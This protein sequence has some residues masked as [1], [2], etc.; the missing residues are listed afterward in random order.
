MREGT[1]TRQNPMVNVARRGTGRLRTIPLAVLLL[2]AVSCA[3][4]AGKASQAEPGE[5]MPSPATTVERGVTYSVQSVRAAAA[6]TDAGDPTAITVFIFKMDEPTNPPCAQLNPTARVQ[7]QDERS[8]VVGSFAYR[9]PSKGSIRCSYLELENGASPYAQVQLHLQAPLGSRA[10]I[11]ENSGELIGIANDQQVPTPGYVPAGYRP[12][13]L[14]QTFNAR[15]GFVGLRQYRS[16]SGGDIEIR[17][18]SATASSESGTVLLRTSVR[19]AQAVI[20]QEDYQR[21][22]W[23][24]DSAHLVREVCSLAPGGTYLSSG[25]L[26]RIARGLP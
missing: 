1:L 20:T 23:W 21:C 25:V 12:T 18:R 4:A 22:V 17:L 7:R 10:L 26:L 13:S 24:T 6:A 3:S 19:A 5:K 11:D 15:S 8:V 2:F 16:N 9:V 14:T